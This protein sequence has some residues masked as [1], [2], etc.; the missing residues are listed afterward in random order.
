M[1]S[2]LFPAAHC[3]FNVASG[4]PVGLSAALVVEFLAAR[5][6]DVELGPSLFQMET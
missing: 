1:I 6:A 2:V 5:Y 3:P 4:L